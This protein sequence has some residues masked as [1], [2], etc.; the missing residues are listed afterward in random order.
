M[1]CCNQKY[2]LYSC[3][4]V[5][6]LCSYHYV[7]TLE[8]FLKPMRAVIKIWTIET[9]FICTGALYGR[10]CSNNALHI[11]L[12]RH[13]LACIE[14]YT[15]KHRNINTKARNIAIE[16]LVFCSLISNHAA[17]TPIHHVKKRIKKC[18]QMKSCPPSSSQHALGSKHM[19]KSISIESY[20]ISHRI[21]SW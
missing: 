13:R 18:N 11:N 2:F 19:S 8:T 14:I 1:M 17:G 9:S 5:W 6:F 20:A 15:R 12:Q 3:S 7:S 21:K 16:T 4:Y 10:T